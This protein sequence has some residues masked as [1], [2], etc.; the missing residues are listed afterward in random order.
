MP[1][2]FPLQ[3]MAFQVNLE[4]LETNPELLIQCEAHTCTYIFVLHGDY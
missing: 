2:P 4:L 3:E 1:V